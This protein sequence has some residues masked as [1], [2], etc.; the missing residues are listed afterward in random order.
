MQTTS[1]PVSGRIYTDSLIAGPKWASNSLSF[2]FPTASTQFTGYP[3]GNEPSIGFEALNPI[4]QAAVRAIF[5]SISSFTNLTFTESTGTNAA[6]AVLR[7]GM[8]DDVGDM[9]PPTP[10]FRARRTS[11]A[12]VGMQTAQATTTI[13]SA[14]TTL[15]TRFSMKSGIL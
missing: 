13:P 3:A 1:V 4:Q 11:V 15:G 9:K 8:T 5:A 10:I 6:S 14:A 12:T 7:F 2:S